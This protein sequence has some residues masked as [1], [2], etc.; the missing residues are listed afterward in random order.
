MT[1]PPTTPVRPLISPVIVLVLDGD[2]CCSHAPTCC[3]LLGSDHLLC[4]GVA[5]FSRVEVSDVPSGIPFLR[6]WPRCC[7]RS[8]SSP[9]EPRRFCRSLLLSSHQRS[10]HDS[11]R[12]VFRDFVNLDCMSTCS[13]ALSSAPEP[14]CVTQI[15][16]QRV[17]F[18]MGPLA[19]SCLFRL[20]MQS[21]GCRIHSSGCSGLT[22]TTHQGTP[23]QPTGGSILRQSGYSL[24]SFALWGFVWILQGSLTECRSPCSRSRSLGSSAWGVVPILWKW[25][26]RPTLTNPVLAILIW[27]IWANPILAN[28]FL[29][30]VCVMV[31]PRR[32][33]S[34]A[35]W[36]PKISR[37]FPSPARLKRRDP[38]MCTCGVP[39]CRVKPGGPKL[40]PIYKCFG[41]TCVVLCCVLCVVCCVCCV[42]C[43]VLLCGVCVVVCVVW[44]RRVG[45]K[46]GRPSP[47][48]PGFTRQPKSPNVHI[49][50]SRPSKKPPKF[51]E[52][53]PRERERGKERAKFWAVQRRGVQGSRNQQQ[54]QQHQ[55]MEGGGQTQNKCG[56]EGRR[57]PEW[58]SRVGPPSPWCWS[59]GLG[60][61]FLGSEF[62]TKTLKLAE[63]GLA[64]VGQ[65]AGQS[66]FGQSRP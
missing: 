57:G 66:R 55:E 59:L 54:P 46:R 65:R 41:R 42:C 30:P 64:K 60:W 63:V 24:R 58:A 35:G 53:S 5:R 17:L 27:P 2:N 21:T 62:L 37:F 32:V 6:D 50:G 14:S 39:G 36:G 34:L 20:S 22:F 44:P 23:Q 38:Q 45:P 48:S 26:K 52:K 15:V 7:A 47:K 11:G 33:G 10:C 51:H 3:H 13:K 18:G 25:R 9:S 43:C 61:A 8:T 56:P 4:I 1:E 12:I 40:R 29:D 16:L 28:P 49:G 19:R 31:G